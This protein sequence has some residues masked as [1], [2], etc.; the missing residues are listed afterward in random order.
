[1]RLTFA[2]YRDMV[3]GCWAGKNAGGVLGAP[4]EGRR[5]TFDVD[6]YTQDLSDGPPPNDDLDLQLAWL[7]AVEDH[8]AA[9]DADILAEYWLA[10]IIPDWAEYGM[11]KANLRRG[12]PPPLSAMVG[13]PYRNSCGAFIRSE[14]WACLNPGRPDRAAYY[15]YQDATVDHA[16]E[17]AAAE[18]FC[19]AVQS[20]AFVEKDPRRLIEIGL[21][22]VPENGALARAV[23]T[24]VQARDDGVDWK[25]ARRRLRH[26]TPGTFGVQ[27]N[28][29]L[30]NP[31][32]DDGT[33]VGAPGFDAP[34]NVGYV[35]LGWLYGEG[36]FGK[37]ICIAN[38]CGEDTDCTAATLGGILG[39]VAGY[40]ALPRKWLDPL[41]DRIAVMCVNRLAW[42][43]QLPKTIVE[44]SERVMRQ[45]PAF[46]A[47]G[48][49]DLFADGPG[50]AL[51]LP[52]ADRLPRDRSAASLPKG[53]N[54][55]MGY[56]PVT[57]RQRLTGSARRLYRTFPTMEVMVD[58]GDEATFSVDPANPKTLKVTVWHR[59]RDLQQYWCA[60]R[61]HVPDGVVFTDGRDAETAPL[62]PLANT[63]AEYVFSMDFAEYT[64]PSVS[65]LV[66][67]ALEGRPTYA[68]LRLPL[69]RRA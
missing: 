42:R 63:P 7:Q 59:M 61:V 20:A 26:A 60:V 12:F 8:G 14:L 48:E 65:I 11:G 18:V 67:I 44:L 13:N 69:I 58:V 54:G 29:L 36:D 9:V 46:M 25:E 28:N 37:S 41:G 33:P 1:M 4:F 16:E 49:C 15:A 68:T 17:G 34:E 64:Q 10:F 47:P 21:S 22:F 32:A 51:N 66:E 5:G 27:G 39:V 52:D 57:M 45:T 24:V 2:A 55:G 35:I 50:Y 40:D 56:P 19:A 3:M 31:P 62:F 38:N 53:L 6:F 23:R 43:I 30:D